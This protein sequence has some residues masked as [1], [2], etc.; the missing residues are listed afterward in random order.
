MFGDLVSTLKNLK[1]D[2]EKGI[3]G[4]GKRAKV[5]P[6]G[7]PALL[8]HLDALSTNIDDEPFSPET[9]K[10]YHTDLLHVP[11]TYFTDS[12]ITLHR[13]STSASAK[14]MR[15][16]SINLPMDIDLDLF[17]ND[18]RRKAQIR[19]IEFV[20]HPIYFKGSEEE[21]RVTG[22][23]WS[24]FFSQFDVKMDRTKNRNEKL[25]L[26]H[27]LVDI[28][29]RL[30]KSETSVDVGTWN[31]ERF[32][33]IVARVTSDILA[34]VQE[35]NA[36]FQSQ[37]AAMRSQG[38]NNGGGDRA[39]DQSQSPNKRQREQDGGE[40][41]PRAGAARDFRDQDERKPH[42]AGP[43]GPYCFGCLEV[44]V[45]GADPSFAA[46]TKLLLVKKFGNLWKF[47]FKLPSEL[48]S[49]EGVDFQSSSSGP[50][51]LC[52][53]LTQLSCLRTKLGPRFASTG[54]TPWTDSVAI[55]D[56]PE[57]TGAW[58]A[59]VPTAPS[60][61]S[62]SPEVVMEEAIAATKPVEE[63]TEVA[64]E[65]VE[66]VAE[67]TE[68]ASEVVIDI[69]D[70]ESFD[71]EE[72]FQRHVS[73]LNPAGFERGLLEL[74]ADY[75]PTFQPL[76][77]FLRRGFSLGFAP[78]DR[79][80]TESQCDIP[81][82]QP[83]G[84]ERDVALPY[85]NKEIAERRM[86]PGMSQEQVEA[87]LAKFTT[88][89]FKSS[90]M[91]VAFENVK[92]RC[93]SNYSYTASNRYPSTNDLLRHVP[94][95]TPTHWCTWME[96]ERLV[97]AAGRG[98]QALT[99]DASKAFRQLGAAPEDR[100]LTF[101]SF[102][103]RHYPDAC[104]CMGMVPATDHFGS[105]MDFAR[106][107]IQTRHPDV[108]ARAWV[109]DGYSILE[110]PFVGHTW[111]SSA[112]E[113]LKVFIMLGLLLNALKYTP[114]A[115]EFQSLGYLWNLRTKVV[116]LLDTKR[117][118]YLELLLEVSV[119]NYYWT[120]EVVERMSG[121]LAWI[122]YVVPVGRFHM[123]AIYSWQGSF[124]ANTTTKKQ[125][126]GSK[127]GRLT[128][129]LAFWVGLLSGTTPISKVIQAV[130]Y[131]D[132]PMFIAS[133]ASNGHIG[134]W[135]GEVWDQFRLRDGWKGGL[136][137]WNID[138]PEAVGV[139]LAIRCF[140]HLFPATTG[141]TLVVSCDN[142]SVVASWLA[143]RSR[144]PVVNASLL[145]IKEMLLFHQCDM[146]LVWIDT[147]ANIAADK[148]SRDELPAGGVGRWKR[149]KLATDSDL[150][151]LLENMQ[152]R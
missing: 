10:R 55:E 97:A 92:P 54:R 73:P 150:G 82:K 142:T 20:S 5:G 59:R 151:R 30:S 131:P 40:S 56:A 113:I 105:V 112:S 108:V 141:V 17:D 26:L 125:T 28:F 86:G 7:D 103:G 144:N 35:Q 62:P 69:F 49:R 78:E 116:T 84:K 76:L 70:V 14:I 31:D 37:M 81:K 29:Y 87:K 6:G 147:V 74:P 95:R 22:E 8:A 85:L 121:F 138:Y 152:F 88:P 136:R 77:E 18:A 145:R 149:P 46:C 120:L 90:P 13:D 68:V 98:A 118:K 109:D 114:P 67:A 123:S 134:F 38:G 61:T 102:N 124:Y 143:Q 42:L 126:Q 101:S 139:E 71:L 34:K 132:C 80:L 96:T 83:T 33:S 51:E 43:G 44:H 140:F 11:L 50:L 110:Q 52:S 75:R 72:F 57:T 119:E 133:D 47:L 137:G 19:Y 89:F 25:F 9:I 146:R 1:E 53:W 79:I 36:N 45:A 117:A 32:N 27:Y 16:K 58:G 94:P 100:I 2:S 129:E 39:R 107:I 128:E 65:A 91:H 21:R 127:V 122:C 3:Q 24:D 63:T 93:V 135:V 66:E 4:K 12:Y 115:E 106:V 148:I 64:V 104:I 60:T 41:A 111:D 48:G 15:D 23:G 99:Y 130:P